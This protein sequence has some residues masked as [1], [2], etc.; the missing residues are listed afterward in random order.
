M[1]S[2]QINSFKISQGKLKFVFDWTLFV[3]TQLIK[4]CVP[5]STCPSCSRSSPTKRSNAKIQ[6][7]FRFSSPRTLQEFEEKTCKTFAG[8]CYKNS[9]LREN[10]KLGVSE[11]S[12]SVNKFHGH[13]RGIKL[14]FS[15]TVFTLGLKA[16][17]LEKIKTLFSESFGG[18]CAC[19][20]RLTAVLSS[21]LRGT[22]GSWVDNICDWKNENEGNN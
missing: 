7:R 21:P 17:I 10:Y 19:H 18:N 22:S 3:W 16:K 12:V 1:E 5:R 14:Y 8:K 4:L 15:A 2:N 20:P 13:M 6:R 11:N 9:T